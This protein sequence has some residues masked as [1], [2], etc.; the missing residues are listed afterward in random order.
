MMDHQSATHS[1]QT[2]LPLDNNDP[3]NPTPNPLAKPICKFYKK[4]TYRLCI[5]RKGW[6]NHHPHAC[7]KPVQFGNRGPC[8]W[9]M[10]LYPSFTPGCVNNLS[11][12]VNA[13]PLIT[14]YMMSRAL[15]GQ[16]Q[17]I[18]ELLKKGTYWNTG[19]ARFLVTALQEL[20]TRLMAAM[21]NELKV[22]QTT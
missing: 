13:S 22:L 12:P 1:T 5:S 21:H 11:L 6:P 17:R 10:K 20:E 16:H 8:M 14:L 2:F 19:N 18:P 15:N 7:K 3:W 9:R 4:C